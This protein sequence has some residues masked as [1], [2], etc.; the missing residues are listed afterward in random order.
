MVWAEDVVEV[1]LAEVAVLHRGLDGD[2][3]EDVGWKMELVADEGRAAGLDGV[4]V[5]DGVDGPDAVV[6]DEGAFGVDGAVGEA[7]GGGVESA[8]GA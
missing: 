8:V 1:G 4:V 2:G 7:V 6:V 3:A 5:G